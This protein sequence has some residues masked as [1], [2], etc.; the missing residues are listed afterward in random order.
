MVIAEAKKDQYIFK[1]GDTGNSF[2]IIYE[3]SVDV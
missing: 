2:F 1:Q 3:G